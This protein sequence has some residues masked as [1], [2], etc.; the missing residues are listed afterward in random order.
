MRRLKSEPSRSAADSNEGFEGLESPIVRVA[1]HLTWFTGPAQSY[2]M[3]RTVSAA[4]ASVQPVVRQQ[5]ETSVH[6]CFARI[7]IACP[8][9]AANV[10]GLRSGNLNS[11]PFFADSES[12][13][14][15]GAM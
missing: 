11:S 14:E 3:K 13:H 15:S 10:A 1:Q 7:A 12:P 5:P 2:W 6:H 8:S 9:A 4:R